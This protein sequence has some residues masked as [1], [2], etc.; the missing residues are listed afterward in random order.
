[1]GSILEKFENVEIKSYSRLSPEDLK[2]CEEQQELYDKTRLHYLRMFAG[3]EKLQHQ[4][5][6]FCNRMGQQLEESKSQ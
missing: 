5:L 2:F 1:M 4:E 3:M 6:S